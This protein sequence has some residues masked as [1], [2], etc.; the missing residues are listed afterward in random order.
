MVAFTIHNIGFEQ[1]FEVTMQRIRPTLRAHLLEQ[2]AETLKPLPVEL[3]FDAK[4]SADGD[5]FGPN[6]LFHEPPELY[7]PP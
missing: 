1:L 2:L 7:R 6:V 4:R 3:E 5:D